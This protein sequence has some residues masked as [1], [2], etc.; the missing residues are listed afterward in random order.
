MGGPGASLSANPRLVL[1]E[2]LQGR[3]IVPEA[4]HHQVIRCL[5]P[6]GHIRDLLGHARRDGSPFTE[7]QEAAAQQISCTQD[8]QHSTPTLH[9]NCDDKMITVSTSLDRQAQDRMPDEWLASPT[10]DADIV[11]GDYPI[12]IA[13][14][15][16]KFSRAPG[17]KS[18][19]STSK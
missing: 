7:A 9:C 16:E 3:G 12:G 19:F 15:T 1:C 8:S 18:F 13:G 10:G 4:P 14:F 6:C 17:Q 2:S 5:S 11:A